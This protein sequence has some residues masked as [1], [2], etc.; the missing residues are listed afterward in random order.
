LKVDIDPGGSAPAAIEPF[1]QCLKRHRV[2]LR[3]GPVRTL[4][5]NLGFL[6]NQSCRHCHL[7]AGPD[8]QEVMSRKTMDQVIAFARLN[9]FECL[10]ITGGA[11][12]MNPELEYLLS[13]LAPLAPRLMLRSNL[14]ALAAGCR[15]S[16]L[17]IC[18][19]HK[20]VIIGSL[21]AL[22]AAQT[23]A[24]RGRGVMENS[25]R[26]LVKLNALG[27][28]RPA[29][30][31][32]LDLVTSP[33]GA[34]LPAA[35][36]QAE[37]KFRQ[38]LESRLGITFSRLY[39]FANV[40]LGRFYQ[41]LE[42]SGNLSGYMDRLV[43]GFNPA[44]IDGLMCRNLVSVSWDGYLYDCDFNLAAGR[45]P[46]G[47]PRHISQARDLPAAGDFIATGDYCYACTAGS[48][49]T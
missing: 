10:D 18:R 7:V 21:P 1:Y 26:M 42:Q 17:E 41:W 45:H 13:Q 44:A 47:G 15:E 39:I 20:V 49:F 38:H 11:P 48:G 22:N 28:G 34:F 14:T 24:V 6:C 4:Q 25:L 33:A 32:E 43:S 5:V 3:R 19:R 23:D 16:L 46:V 40:P 12:E 31:L 9:R 2:D 35:Q 36:C 8:R 29:T 37:K 27:Y 30:G